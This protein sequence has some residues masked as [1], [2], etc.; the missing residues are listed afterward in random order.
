MAIKINAGN[1]R[2][3]SGLRRHWIRTAT[4]LFACVANNAFAAE[5]GQPFDVSGERIDIQAP[6]GWKLAWMDGTPNGSYLQEFIPENEDINTWRKGYLSIR[7]I[8]YPPAATVEE[9][10]RA[11]S[12]VADAA[13]ASFMKATAANCSEKHT[14]MSQRANDFN[15]V[16]FAVGGGFCDRHGPAMP[17][18]EGAIIAFVE[19]RDFLFFMQYGWRPADEREAQSNLPLR[20]SSDVIRSYLEAIKAT[21]LCGGAGQPVCK[22]QNNPAQ[23]TPEESKASK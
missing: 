23:P 8:A 5:K 4:V 6:A 2:A 21:S 18:G 9:I 15:G 10:K 1:M 14:A 16:H 12:H 13:L 11:N 22:Y 19:G 17:F 7:R 20:Q 3:L